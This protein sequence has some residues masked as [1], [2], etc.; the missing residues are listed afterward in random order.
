MSTDEETAGQQQSFTQSTT[1]GSPSEPI[2]VHPVDDNNCKEQPK[3][4]TK[5]KERKN[6]A[7][8]YDSIIDGFTQDQEL[9]DALRGF[10]QYRVA[11]AHRSKKEFTN[12]ALKLNL[13]KLR[14]L[15]TDPRVMT[16]IVNQTVEKGWS[17]FY[18]PKDETQAT[19]VY[20]R[21]TKG[22]Q[23]IDLSDFEESRKKW[24]EYIPEEVKR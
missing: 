2:A 7:E 9:R 3:Q 24:G 11:S 22:Q 23:E 1:G 8:T 4:T 15:S 19:V 16:K 21:G 17:G 14:S 10:L 20:G 5:K 13:T 6:T 18:D 12:R